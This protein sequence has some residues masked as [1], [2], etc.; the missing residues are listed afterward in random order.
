MAAGGRNDEH[1]G[2]DQHT[3]EIVDYYTLRYREDQRL[4]ARP[5]A[6][7]EW[8]RTTQLLRDLLPGP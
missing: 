1:Q 5:Q 8:I 3:S 2:V 7:L 6:R 4:S